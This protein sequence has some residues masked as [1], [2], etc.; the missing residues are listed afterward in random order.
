MGKGQTVVAMVLAKV[1]VGKVKEEEKGERRGERRGGRSVL[2]C[3]AGKVDA[4][5]LRG[6][7]TVSSWR[8]PRREEQWE[9]SSM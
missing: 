4:A 3:V 2:W 6:K 1:E 5:G 7:A 9:I 8:R